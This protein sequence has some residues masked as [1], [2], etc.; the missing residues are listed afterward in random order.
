MGVPRTGRTER[1]TVTP[2]RFRLQTA[3]LRRLRWTPTDLNVV[4]HF[5]DKGAIPPR[6]YV[7]TF[8]DGFADLYD[9]VL[10]LLAERSMPAVVY[11]VADRQRAD[12]MDWGPLGPHRLLSWSQIAEL[13]HA[14][15]TIGSHGRTHTD[16]R[17]CS[18]RRLDDEV[19]GSRRLIEDKLGEPVHHFCYPYGYVNEAAVHAVRRAEY[20]TA[21]TTERG[22]VEAG[23]DPLQLPRLTVGKNMRTVRFA[24]RILLG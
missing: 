18:A 17:A 4:H 2:E 1:L 3:L 21:C 7:L 23:A 5:L 19:R 24:K 22:M 10:P 14:G 11:V 16:L 8:D 6:Y 20:T 15:I 9:H 12:W 13:A